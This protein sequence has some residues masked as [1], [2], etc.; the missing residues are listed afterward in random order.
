MSATKMP[1][2]GSLA[3]LWKSHNPL[4]PSFS[5]LLLSYFEVI[6]ATFIPFNPISGDFADPSQ[7]KRSQRVNTPSAVFAFLIG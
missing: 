4:P 7:V 6:T 1:L 2:T 3:I 5:L